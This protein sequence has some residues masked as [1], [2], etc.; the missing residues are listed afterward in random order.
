MCDVH[1]DALEIVDHIGAKGIVTHFGHH[2][3]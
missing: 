3:D 1:T 2:A